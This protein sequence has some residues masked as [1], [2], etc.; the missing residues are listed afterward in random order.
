MNKQKKSSSVNSSI[1]GDVFHPGEFVRDEMEARGINQQ[2]FAGKLHI[3]KSEMSL[4]LNGYRNITPV[5]AIKIE[6]AWGIDA[7]FWMNLQVKYDIDLLKKKHKQA[8]QK[9]KISTKKK[10]KFKKLIKAA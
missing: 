2:E 1:P 6:K 7:E 9:T 4:L 5:I 3:S 10:T 8:L